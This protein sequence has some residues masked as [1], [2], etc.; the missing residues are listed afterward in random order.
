MRSATNSW[1]FFAHLCPVS[2]TVGQSKPGQNQRM[3]RQITRQITIIGVGL[4]GGSFALALRDA[5]CSI[6]FVGAGRSQASLE[7]AMERGIIDSWTTSLADSVSGS[8]VVLLATPVGSVDAIMTEIAPALDRDT[9]VTDVG[10]VKQSVIEAAQRRLPYFSRFVPV[11]PIAGTEHSGVE[12][13]F[14][15][16]YHN[17]RLIL[18]PVADTS[19]QALETVSQ[20]W[21]LTGAVIEQMDPLR[22]D[23]V[24]AATSHLPHLLAFSLVETLCRMDRDAPL[25]QHTGGGFADYTRIA[26]SDPVMWRDIC[27]Y[28]REALL[29]TLDEYKHGLDAVA[30]AIENGDGETLQQ[31]FTTAKETRDNKVLTVDQLDPKKTGR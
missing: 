14:A 10:S 25:L 13:G 26:S 17:K 24:F 27:L 29:A 4:I 28:N 11:H 31:I 5:G 6:R 8:D 2:K 15:T 22:H 19:E 30:E 21:Q 7:R 9:I 12:A 16:L 20:L 18:T 23:E 3:A 1:C